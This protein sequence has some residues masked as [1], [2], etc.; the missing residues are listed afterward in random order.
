MMKNEKNPYD[1]H[2]DETAT[3]N[4][5]RVRCLICL[6]LPPLIPVLVDLVFRRYADSDVPSFITLGS[7]LGA[8]MWADDLIGR[9]ELTSWRLVVLSV[10]QV[11]LVVAGPLIVAHCIGN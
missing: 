8:I 3:P 6:T 2:A 9:L 10:I 7:M 4:V 11:A 1:A 5:T